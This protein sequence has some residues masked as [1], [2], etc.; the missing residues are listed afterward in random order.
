MNFLIFSAIRDEKNEDF[1][2]ANRILAED[3]MLYEEDAELSGAELEEIE[4]SSAEE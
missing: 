1:K 2:R 4:N 3:Q